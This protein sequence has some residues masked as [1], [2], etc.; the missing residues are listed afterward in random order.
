MAQQAI[1]VANHKSKTATLNFLD[2]ENNLIAFDQN[3]KPLIGLNF[4]YS[5]IL[6]YDFLFESLG[7]IDEENE[8]FIFKIL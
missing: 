4:P 7:K 1:V 6:D 8:K 2:E 3:N 5:K